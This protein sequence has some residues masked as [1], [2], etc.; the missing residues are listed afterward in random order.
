[1]CNNEET[2]TINEKFCVK[3]FYYMLLDRN[4][5]KPA[6]HCKISESTR[7]I[8]DNTR[9]NTIVALWNSA[10]FCNYR[11]AMFSN[12]KYKLCSDACLKNNLLF[13]DS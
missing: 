3:P 4:I 1:M 13:M 9:D 11:K 8:D 7:E 5:A 10:T 12:Y 6:C 2:K